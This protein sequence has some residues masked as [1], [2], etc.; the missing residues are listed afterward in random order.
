MGALLFL[1]FVGG[2]VWLFAA[3]QHDQ[4]NS[5]GKSSSPEPPVQRKPRVRSYHELRRIY[6]RTSPCDFLRLPLDVLQDDRFLEM[7]D[8]LYLRVLDEYDD[9][10]GNIYRKIEAG[11]YRHAERDPSVKERLALRYMLPDN[12]NPALRGPS[13]IPKKKRVRRSDW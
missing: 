6:E 1:A 3:N 9:V 12:L 10:P 5:F 2:L 11:V 13:V 8:V 4:K 7:L